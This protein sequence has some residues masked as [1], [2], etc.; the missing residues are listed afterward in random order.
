[1][2]AKRNAD[3]MRKQVES[4]QRAHEI[5]REAN[6]VTEDMTRRAWVSTPRA[7]STTCAEDARDMETHQH[8]EGN[9]AGPTNAAI[10]P[11]PEL[12]ESVSREMYERLVHY[13]NKRYAIVIDNQLGSKPVILG[14]PRNIDDPEDSYGLLAES[15]VIL[16]VKDRR[17]KD[18][19]GY[20]H[21]YYWW[22]SR[23]SSRRVVW[24]VVFKP[25]EPQM[26]RGAYNMG[27]SIYRAL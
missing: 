22:W 10:V 16:H 25:G 23:S 15:A 18:R 8:V 20:S 19:R 11:D 14:F 26:V 1:M 3:D 6:G 21:D 24:G 17:L 12:A 4:L 5:A 2:E 7:W 9:G 13:M 27:R